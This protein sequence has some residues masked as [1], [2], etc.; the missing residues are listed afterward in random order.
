MKS[1]GE[2]LVKPVIQEAH[3][4]FKSDFDSIKKLVFLEIKVFLHIEQEVLVLFLLLR[5][6]CKITNIFL[7]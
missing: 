3:K 7:T 4:Y 6:L 5:L 2:I 1:K